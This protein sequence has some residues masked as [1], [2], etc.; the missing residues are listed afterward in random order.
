MTLSTH[1]AAITCH[2]AVGRAY[3]IERERELWSAKSRAR[4]RFRGLDQAHNYRRAWCV[5]LCVRGV[6]H[7]DGLAVDGHQSHRESVAF[8]LPGPEAVIGPHLAP[9]RR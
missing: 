6:R 3:G 2:D 1:S 8:G 9:L 5:E 7:C 4:R